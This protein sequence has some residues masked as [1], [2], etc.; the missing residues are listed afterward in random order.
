MKHIIYGFGGTLLAIILIITTVTISGKM[1]RKKEITTSLTPAL[2]QSIQTLKQ[3]KKYTIQNKE[4]FVSD[5]LQNLLVTIENNSDIKIEIMSADEEKGLLGIKVTEYYKNP[6]NSIGSTSCSKIVLFDNEEDS[7][8]SVK[9][10]D[11]NGNLKIEYKVEANDTIP[12]PDNDNWYLLTEE[13]GKY[14]IQVFNASQIS[15]LQANNK[16]LE[17]KNNICNFSGSNCIH[18]YKNNIGLPV[19]GTDIN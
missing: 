16:Y 5:V 3:T 6:N 1:T 7:G 10:T 18:F 19:N 12:C 2:D 4:E 15:K 14:H 9:Y 17:P 11:E 8:Y 13:D